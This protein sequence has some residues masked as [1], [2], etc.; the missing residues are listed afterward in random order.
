MIAR[1]VVAASGIPS[2][3][4]KITPVSAILILI[5]LFVGLFAPS[6][7][8]GPDPRPVSDPASDPRVAA[9]LVT[10]GDYMP[11]P[12]ADVLTSVQ[13]SALVPVY[14]VYA[15]T[16]ADC[17]S[18]ARTLMITGDYAPTMRPC[19]GEEDSPAVAV[20]LELGAH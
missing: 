5:A 11:A 15:T 8:A 16:G 17:A 2:V 3:P 6:S 7:V 14:D 9:I 13:W 19:L 4:R 20:L 18:H 10:T 12:G 1:T